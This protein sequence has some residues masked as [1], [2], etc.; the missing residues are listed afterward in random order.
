[1]K[2]WICALSLFGVAFL[3]V[4]CHKDTTFHWITPEAVVSLPTVTPMPPELLPG[5][6][7]GVVLPEPTPA[8]PCVVVKGNISADGRKLYHLPGMANYNQVKIDEAK[9]EKFFC[10]EQEALDNGWVRAGN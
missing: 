3:S 7:T 1:M 10:S 6:E 5:E 9:G 2:K 8:P 4:S